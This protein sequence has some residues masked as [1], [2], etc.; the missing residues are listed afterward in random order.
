MTQRMLI[1]FLWQLCND[2]YRVLLEDLIDRARNHGGEMGACFLRL[3]DYMKMY[4]V[5]CSNQQVFLFAC[6]LCICLLMRR[7]PMNVSV[8]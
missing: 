7:T 4:S 3:A 6:L 1:L 2:P 5:Y 8:V